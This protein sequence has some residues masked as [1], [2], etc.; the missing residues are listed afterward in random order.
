MRRNGTPT[1]RKE[2]PTVM[3]TE[4]KCSQDGKTLEIRENEQTEKRKRSSDVEMKTPVKTAD[5]EKKSEQPVVMP[6]VASPPKT[7]SGRIRKLP[8]YLKDYQT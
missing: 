5:R 6:K 7:R 8:M 3:H 4:T 1:E 2:G